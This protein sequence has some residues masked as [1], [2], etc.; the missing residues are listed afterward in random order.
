MSAEVF[1]LTRIPSLK[2]VEDFRR[3]VASLNI[4]LPCEDQI[5]AGPVAKRWR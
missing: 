2:T 1:K 5:A 3:H 4:D